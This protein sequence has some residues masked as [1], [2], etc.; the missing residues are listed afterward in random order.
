M[1]ATGS[2]LPRLCY[3]RAMTLM[4]AVLLGIVEGL[5][6]FLPVSSTGHL[7]LTARLFGLAQTEFMKTFEIA[8][9]LG[10]IVAVVTLYARTL[11][12]DREIL[13][14]VFA[15][16]LPTALIG[17]LLYKLIK[18]FLF[19]GP[20][21]VLWSL[22][23]GGI[24]LILFDRWH[25]EK[26][27]ALKKIADI[28]LWKA[29]AIGVIQSLSVVPGLSRAGAS[30]VGALALG[31]DRKTAVEFSFLLAVPTLTAATVY[32]LLKNAPAFDGGEWKLLCVG[33]LA[34]FVVAIASIRL[35][36]R[37]VQTRGLTAF[38]I[39]RILAALLFWGFVR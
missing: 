37:F 31:V 34:S 7:I 36:L 22:F 30:I 15:A 23:L 27:E 17:F 10:A 3:N 25:R 11:L 1:S 33:G 39:Y 38:G 12:T 13:K 28:P 26:N 14:R 32:D 35:F 2:A 20:S 29:S 19:A 4:H 18:K 24:V 9:Q 16:F 6:E 8:I 21:I 5:T